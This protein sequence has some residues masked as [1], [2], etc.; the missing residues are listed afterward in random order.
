[1]L[2]TREEQQA[3]RIDTD[4]EDPD[5]EADAHE[6][7]AKAKMKTAEAEVERARDE[8]E[9]RVKAALSEPKAAAFKQFWDEI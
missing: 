6:Q 7:K 8:A 3:H 2:L 4:A 5:A 9:N 1:V